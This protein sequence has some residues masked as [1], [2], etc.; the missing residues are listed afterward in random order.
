MLKSTNKDHAAITNHLSIVDATCRGY[1]SLPVFGVADSCLL[2]PPTDPGRRI[3]KVIAP[4]FNHNKLSTQVEIG[5]AMGKYVATK[6]IEIVAKDPPIEL[7]HIFTHEGV[8]ANKE[9]DA[10]VFSNRGGYCPPLKRTQAVDNYAKFIVPVDCSPGL[11]PFGAGAIATQQLL[12]FILHIKG[13]DDLTSRDSWDT[14]LTN[15]KLRY[16]SNL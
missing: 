13:V 8:L 10:G 1:L 2:R 12:K 15:K 16:N 4:P 11:I 14:V 7:I 5:T 6:V 3:P 9:C